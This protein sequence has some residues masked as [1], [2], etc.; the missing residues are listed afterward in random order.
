LLGPE[1]IWIEA[2]SRPSSGSLSLAARSIVIVPP[3]R[4][5]SASASAVGAS[6]TFVKLMVAA[7]GPSVRAPSLTVTL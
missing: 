7:R 1:T 2:R 3:S 6:F 4:A 5:V